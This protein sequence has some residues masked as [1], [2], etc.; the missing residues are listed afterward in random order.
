MGSSLQCCSSSGDRTCCN[1]DITSHEPCEQQGGENAEEEELVTTLNLSSVN[2]GEDVDDTLGD[3]LR[4]LHE[5]AQL[6]R[7][8]YSVEASEK[9]TSAEELHERSPSSPAKHIVASVMRHD[10]ELKDLK[11]LMKSMDI[12]NFAAVKLLN[13]VPPA[14]PKVDENSAVEPTRSRSAAEAEQPPSQQPSAEIIVDPAQAM[15]EEKLAALEADLGTV[16]SLCRAARVLEAYPAL[17][18]LQKEMDAALK[19]KDDFTDP[20]YSQVLASLQKKLSADPMLKKVGWM[21]ARTQEAAALLN[22]PNDDRGV[23]IDV[24]D[25][26]LGADFTLRM[27]LRFA[28]G[29]E[30]DAN[31]PSTQLIIRGDITGFP[32]SLARCITENCET[33]LLQKDWVKDCKSVTGKPG[34]AARLYT[35]LSSMSLSPALLPFKLDDVCLREFIVCP[36]EGMVKDRGPGVMVVEYSPPDD[37]ATEFE[38]MPLPPKKP[39][40][41]R[42]KGAKRVYYK[43]QSQNPELSNMLAIAKLNVPFP[44][45]LLPISLLGRIFADGFKSSILLLKD[46]LYDKWD[47]KEYKN[48]GPQCPDFYAAVS[49]LPP[50]K[51]SPKVE[52]QKS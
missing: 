30:R 22:S 48:R 14:S 40:H 4:E 16:R 47:E 37:T 36:G 6:Y 17:D 39:G 51:L 43:T 21:Q 28:E 29:A 18:K 42:L 52:H 33:D 24:K 1:N 49:N 12:E 13:T 41:I 26:K 3:A 9:L 8:G 38:S 25:P 46:G 44:Q 27:T 10:P 45:M 50:D 35:A 31:G 19:L 5:A 2:L 20:Q 7:D 11:L 23:S 15:R 32:A 34:R